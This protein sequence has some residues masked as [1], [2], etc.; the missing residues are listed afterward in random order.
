MATLRGMTWSHPRAYE[1]LQAC[2]EN[3]KARTGVELTWDQRSLQDF[4]SFPI[5]E[6]AA[7]YDLLVIDHPH[8][9]QIVDDCCLEPMDTS[10]RETDLAMIKDGSV[11]GSY[12]SYWWNHRLWALPIDAAAQVQAWRP[13]RLTQ[14]L[15]TWDEVI[16]LARRGEVSVPLRPPHSLMTLLTLLGN[17][18]CRRAPDSVSLV[19]P[20]E[21]ET[22]YEMLRELA[23]LSPSDAQQ[24][25]P[26]S[27][28]DQLSNPACPI[29]ASPYVYGY[30][31]YALPTFRPARISFADIPV[32]GADGVAGSVLG[33]TGIAVSKSSSQRD[34]AK[35]FAFWVASGSIQAGL[36]ADANGQPAHASAWDNDRVNGATSDFYRNTRATMDGAWIRPRHSGYIEFQTQAASLLN[37]M[38]FSSSSA[39]TTIAAI[40]RLYATSFRGGVFE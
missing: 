38:L 33:G 27:L 19:D 25:D 15:Q 30:V 28:L 31:S 13:D 37:E 39:R 36:Y 17:R 6:L 2:S 9:G 32:A 23:A 29:S 21:G 7:R 34:A 24:M 5:R 3:W 26:I 11:G 4:E 1:P 18:G 10:D 16:Q 8:V 40:N 12:R 22:A 35:N 14:P 20:V